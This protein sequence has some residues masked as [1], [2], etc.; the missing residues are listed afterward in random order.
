MNILPRTIFAADFETTTDPE[1]CRVWLWGIRD[2]GNDDIIARGNSISSFIDSALPGTYYFHNS[3][4]DL[5]FIMDYLM[6]EMKY[7]FVELDFSKRG[8]ANGNDKLKHNQFTCLIGDQ[9]QHY[10]FS[11]KNIV[12]E[13]FIVLDSLR[14]AP[15]ALE[16]LGKA[17]GYP[18][19]KGKT[20]I[21]KNLPDDYQPTQ[22]ELDYI[23]VD[24]G[25][26]AHVMR[27]L[28]NENLTSMTIGGDCFKDWKKRF[29]I[30]RAKKNRGDGK[31]ETDED[32]FRRFFPV[33]EEIQDGEI[34]RAYRG[35]WTYVNEKIQGHILTHSGTVYDT[36][37]MYPAVMA[38]EKFPFGN[39]IEIGPGEPAPE[40]HPLTITGA[41]VSFQL[42]PG[43]LPCIPSSAE[44]FGGSGW[45]KRGEEVE[46]WATNQEWDLWN[47]HYDI[48]IDKYLG[49]Y[50]YRA[51]DG[52]DV[53]G[54]Y[55]DYWM[56]IK[57]KAPKNSPQ[58]QLAKLMLTN[59]W[60]K[61]GTNPM[62]SQRAPFLEEGK[63]I[64]LRVLRTRFDNPVYA[65]VAIF[66]ASYARE[67]VITAAQNN[68]D[69]FCY[70]DTD[71]IH[72][73]G[74]ELPEGIEI[75]NFK[76]GAWKH[77]GDWSEAVYCRTKAYVERMKF[78]SPEF[79]VD[80]ETGKQNIMIAMAGL[81][82]EAR[83]GI[84][85]ENVHHGMIFSGN[86]S[87]RRVIG[88]I[89]LSPISWKLDYKLGIVEYN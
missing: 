76:L 58:R 66:T 86:L 2:I 65:P 84:T 54:E 27:F 28:L 23:D 49:G 3:S 15:G 34:R 12:G 43:M 13:E 81:P 18:Y 87:K 21:H 78:E 85:P 63:P 1:N 80:P 39:G 74:I 41:V 6:R 53:F 69:R 30:K 44:S 7:E 14:K 73:V 8:R 68:Y 47:I 25:I 38:Q 51:I 67:R 24:T 72:I 42:K 20:P 16:E 17:Y 37:S 59:L 46:L 57:S 61:F 71:S 62:R 70:A 26:L 56:E 32:V 36:N 88:G 79:H 45:S 19:P 9:G 50:A 22:V 31:Y 35:G 29:S 75:H 55:I 10:L 40:S 5:A 60:G 4:F 33:L 11:W 77:E 89:V 52:A 83:D 48:E 82:K 64:E